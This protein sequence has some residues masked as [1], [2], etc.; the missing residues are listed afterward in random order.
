MKPRGWQDEIIERRPSGIDSAQIDECLRL[1]PT[2]RLER[3]RRFME[4]IEGAR[5]E[6]G[7]RFPET[8]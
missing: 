6:H 4:A 5:D 2:D 1:T 8:G 7:D 3:M